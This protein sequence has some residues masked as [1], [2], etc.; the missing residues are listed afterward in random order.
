MH[1][2]PLQCVRVLLERPLRLVMRAGCTPEARLVIVQGADAES[3]GVMAQ[4]LDC[5]HGHVLR[6]GGAVGV[7]HLLVLWECLF[8]PREDARRGGCLQPN[9]GSRIWHCYGIS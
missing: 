8:W 1:R 4:E 3:S 7:L 5:M 2:P 9:T 6:C